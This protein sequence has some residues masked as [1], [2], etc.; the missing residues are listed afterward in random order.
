MGAAP[1]GLEATKKV[2]IRHLCHTHESRKLAQFA[3]VRQGMVQ[4]EEGGWCVWVLENVVGV[5]RYGCLSPVAMQVLQWHARTLCCAAGSSIH[6]MVSTM[7]YC[8]VLV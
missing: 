5:G 1:Q 6:G 3:E 7:F 2:T 8:N 4:Q